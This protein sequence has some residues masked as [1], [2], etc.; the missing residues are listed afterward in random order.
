MTE[1]SFGAWKSLGARSIRRG[2][3][4]DLAPC[5]KDAVEVLTATL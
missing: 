1:A 4:P 3:G 5:I 2:V